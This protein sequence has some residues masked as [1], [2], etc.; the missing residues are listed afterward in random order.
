MHFLSR[1]YQ[2]GFALGAALIRWKTPITFRGEAALA[3]ATRKMASMKPIKWLIVTDPGIVKSGLLKQ[4]TDLLDQYHINYY[5]YDQV[6]PN[7]TTTLID[8]A[9]MLYQE[10]QCQGLIG[11]GGGSAIDAAKGIGIRIVKPHRAWNQLRGL[12]KVLRRLPPI[13]A[14]PTTAGTGSEVTIAAVISDPLRHEKYAIIDPFLIPSMAVLDASLIVGLPGHLSAS[15]GMDA[16]TH[17]VESYIG[18]GPRFEQRKARR[19]VSLIHR[20]LLASYQQPFARLHRHHMLEASYLAGQAFTRDYV[21]NIH[22]MAHALGALYG[23]PHGFANA[24]IMPHV[25]RYYGQS[26]HRSLARL[27]RSLH[28]ETRLK[29]SEAAE[30]FITWIEELN[31]QMGIPT[32]LEI[33]YRGNMDQL[34]QHAYR[35]ANP[36]Y[37]V[38]MILSRTDF[39]ALFQRVG[40]R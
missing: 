12:L 18:F 4:L 15:T 20:H 8:N 30:L 21:G 26:V 28:P 1:V 16:L 7:P 19:A 22:A 32:S 13:V 2:F 40:C 17:A 36:T 24:I 39:T 5:V 33:P 11:F 29:D 3:T 34:V 10:Q 23:V 38:P 9:A 31:N 25:L 14:V 37:P 27:Y 6:I 35:E